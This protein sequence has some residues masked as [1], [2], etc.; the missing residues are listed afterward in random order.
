MLQQLRDLLDYKARYESE[1]QENFVLAEQN[2][3]LRKQQHTLE[4]DIQ[5]LLRERDAAN[6]MCNQMERS[7]NEM[8]RQFDK[9]VQE[10]DELQT[11][12]CE[13]GLQNDLLTAERDA[14]QKEL[15]TLKSSVEAVV[16]K[17]RM[18]RAKPPSAE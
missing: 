12:N 2:I 8:E 4:M 6:A 17:R 16:T 1:A 3:E 7:Y 9:A 14:L 5:Q 11:A 18:T 13:L 10:R 15:D